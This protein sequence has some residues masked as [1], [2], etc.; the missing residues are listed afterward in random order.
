VSTYKVKLKKTAFR[1][2]VMQS[3]HRFDEK[4]TWTAFFIIVFFNLRDSFFQ[5]TIDEKNGKRE[6]L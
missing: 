6:V 1:F 2:A 3:Y 4:H 5:L